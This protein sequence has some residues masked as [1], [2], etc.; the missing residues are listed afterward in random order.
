MNATRN[1]LLSDKNNTKPTSSKNS[2]SENVSNNK[3]R[4]LFGIILLAI[5]LVIGITLLLGD[6]DDTN[7][8]DKNPKAETHI[9]N[10]YDDIDWVVSPPCDPD[11]LN[12][13]WEETTHPQKKRRTI[14]RDFTNKRT[15]VKIEYH[16]KNKNGEDEPHW[17]RKNPN[18]TNKHNYYLDK[19]GNI[20]EKNSKKSHIYTN[21]K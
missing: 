15:K 14:D 12:E 21:C 20:V 19:Y 5:G 16:P 2:L 1:N 4:V 17:H 3:K 6:D 8:G 7:T 9:D 11:D 10:D 18:S 13:D